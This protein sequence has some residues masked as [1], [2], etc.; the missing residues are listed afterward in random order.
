[1]ACGNGFCYSTAPRTFTVSMPLTTTDANGQTTTQMVTTTTVMTPKL[2]ATNI[3]ETTEKVLQLRPSTVAKMPAIETGG[4]AGGGGSGGL[5]Q[6]ALGGIIGGSIVLLLVILSATWLILRRL[7]KTQ[8]AAEELAAARRESS[9]GTRKD[10]KQSFG[11]PTITEMSMPGGTD[12]LQS[13]S[14]RPSY[15]RTGSDVSARE[16]SP[17]PTTQNHN[18]MTSTAYGAWPGQYNPVP[19]SEAPDSRRPS[20][21]TYHPYDA[22]Y[23]Q[24]SS[25][26]QHYQQQQQGQEQQL[27]Q[28]PSPMHQRAGSQDS[29]MT[30]ANQNRHLSYSSE[31]EGMHGWSELDTDSATGGGGRRR[32]SS[33]AGAMSPPQSHRGSVELPGLSRMRSDSGN[34]MGG[35]TMGAA[36]TGLMTVNEFSELHGY[37][38]PVANAAGQTAARLNRYP[39][40]APTPID[41]YQ[42]PSAGGQRGGPDERG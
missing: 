18:S 15:L 17:A 23:S 27:Q 4:A 39:S 10:K 37:Y 25:Q 29:Q 20:A 32:S 1:M 14:I 26:Y 42:R 19:T 34:G 8:K 31:L 2:G 22:R 38:G 40:I 3:A 11:Q 30:G 12:P 21:E 35:G 13:P 7:K 33:G 36:G 9:K 16:S 5:S 28:G 41:A 6:T 24:Q